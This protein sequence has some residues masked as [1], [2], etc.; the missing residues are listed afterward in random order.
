[1]EEINYEKFLMYLR[2]FQNKIQKNVNDDLK[3]YNISSTHIGIIMILKE[4][5]GCTMSELS[6]LIKVD[7]A[8]MTRNI[9]ELEKIN[10]IYR[11]RENETQRKYKI[12]LTDKG[13]DLAH[14]LEKII[15]I[16]KEE[17]LKNFTK[18]EQEILKQA[19]QLM[20]EKFIDTIE[21]EEKE[22]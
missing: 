17:F 13:K 21:K 7:N 12:C 3:R 18:K 9:K 19:A 2:Q 15:K 22:C 5:K 6:R 1:M 14:E 20:I 16:R 4:E 10:Y 11:N 8:L